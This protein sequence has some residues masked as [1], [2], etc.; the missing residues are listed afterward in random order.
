MEVKEYI[1]IQLTGL[2]RNLQRVLEALTPQEID[3]RPSSG[4]N[5]IGLILFHIARSDDSFV[6]A[7]ILGQKELWRE[8]R[9]YEK[10]GFPATESA[11]QYTTELVN[12]FCAPPLK[13][14][15]AYSQAVHARMVER[16][17]EMKPDQFDKKL[18]VPFFGETTIGAMMAIMT[19][20]ASQHLGEISYLRGLQRGINK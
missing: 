8:D 11:S 3:W 10:L 5:S 19:D 7:N 14:I 17:K 18:T 1:V 6:L 9:W 20:H 2:E 13:D 16:V 4:C 12:A 15:V